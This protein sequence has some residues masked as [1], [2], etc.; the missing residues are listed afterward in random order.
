MRRRADRPTLGTVFVFGAGAS[1]DASKALNPS[2]AHTAPLDKQFCARI[3]S[4]ATSNACPAWVRESAKLIL[5]SWRDAKPFEECGLEEA[6][7][8]QAAHLNFLNAIQ[9]RRLPG[10]R[11]PTGFALRSEWDFVYHLA[12]IVAYALRQCREKPSSPFRRVAHKFF[13]GTRPSHIEN[14]VI[15]SSVRLKLVGST[16]RRNIGIKFLCWGLELQGFTWPLV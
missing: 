13:R 12:H 1:Y 11:S 7:L 9:P 5:E 10:I 15:T 6:V 16:G 3:K 8:L 4:H 2:A 14:T